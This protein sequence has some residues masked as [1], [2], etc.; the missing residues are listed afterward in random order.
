M[1]QLG[2]ADRRYLLLSVIAKLGILILFISSQLQYFSLLH[3]VRQ[4]CETDE[5]ISRRIDESINPILQH[6]PSTAMMNRRE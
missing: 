5:N 4:Q 2:V 3:D 1:L 6:N